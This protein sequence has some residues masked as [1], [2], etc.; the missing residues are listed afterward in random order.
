MIKKAIVVT[1]LLVVGYSIFV[2]YFIGDLNY[3]QHQWQD[4]VIKAQCYIYDDK[5]TFDNVIVGSSLSCRL[6]MDSIPQAY[7]LSFSGQSIFDGLYILTHK[8][9]LPKNI[10]IEMNVVLRSEDKNFTSALYSPVLYYSKKIVPSLREGKQP[11]GIAG[12]SIAHTLTNRV[13]RKTK[14]LFHLTSI[15]D[16]NSNKNNELFSKMLSSAIEDYSKLPDQFLVDESF[17]NLKVYIN[18]L[19]NKGVTIVFFEMPLNAPLNDLPKSNRIR[20]TFY[21]KFPQSTYNYIPIPD[22]IKYETMDGLHLTRDA[23]LKYTLY[24]KSKMKNYFR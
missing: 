9:K 24:L 19:E 4:N 1:I 16:N 15:D 10:F 6:A 12:Y 21:Q 18:E 5:N 11:V 13:V 7:N 22:S 2:A 20:S 14:S 17:N 23:G 8:T 3:S